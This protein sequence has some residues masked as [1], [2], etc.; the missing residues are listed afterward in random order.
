MFLLPNRREVLIAGIYIPD[1]ITHHTYELNGEV[2]IMASSNYGSR[3]VIDDLILL[4]SIDRFPV[5]CVPDT[6]HIVGLY[7]SSVLLSNRRLY[8]GIHEEAHKE[9][10]E[11]DPRH[12]ELVE[13]VAAIC[14]SG[15]VGS[16]L[17]M[18]G[19]G[20]ILDLWTGGNWNTAR[21]ATHN[22]NYTISDVYQEHEVR[23]CCAC[24]VQCP[25]PLA[26]TQH[27]HK[28]SAGV[29]W[30]YHQVTTFD[31]QT[32]TTYLIE[33]RTIVSCCLN[34]QSEVI[35]LFS[36]GSVSKILRQDEYI[37]LSGPGDI[38]HL[39]CVVTDLRMGGAHKCSV[40]GI[41]STGEVVKLDGDIDFKSPISA[42][43]GT[44]STLPRQVTV[45]SA[46][47]VG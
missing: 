31:R 21:E 45:K 46:A 8:V 13:D 1:H 47:S 28:Q 3:V 11:S 29:V 24:N 39:N 23:L 42:V 25:E 44:C 18:L 14:Q 19:N 40:F 30:S 4:P 43:L 34:T 33:D 35:A 12:I 16:A 9:Y 27:P 38:I 2:R 26:I 5:K 36:D 41:H 22:A 20:D 17:V 15:D 32:I 37:E 10:Q 6:T 7:Y